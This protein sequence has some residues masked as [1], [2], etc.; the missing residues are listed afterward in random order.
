MIQLL[1][2]ALVPFQAP[3]DAAEIRVQDLKAH[4]G[5]LASDAMEGRESGERGGHLAARYVASQFER[6]GLQPIGKEPGGLPEDFLLPFEAAGRTC[7]NVAGLLPGTDPALAKRA[8]VIGGHHDHAGIG[9]P[10]AM[11]PPGQIHNGADDNASGTSGVLELA[12]WFAAHPARHPILFMTFSAEE[13]GL[14]GSKAFVKS[15]VFPARAMFAMINM[16]MVGRSTDGY[17][18]VGGLGTAEEFHPLLDGILAR[19]PLKIEAADGGSAPS[20]N[21]P[22]FQ[23]GVPALF[24]FTNVH[25]DYHLPTDDAGRINFKGEVQILG[26]VREV[27]ERLDR[28][29]QA[30]TFVRNGATALPADFGA[31]MQSEMRHARELRAQRGHLGIRVGPPTGKGILVASRDEG[32][33]AAKAG[34][35]AG[36]VI[37]SVGGHPTPTV[38]ELRKALGPLSKGTRVALQIFRDGKELALSATLE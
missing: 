28:A 11:G 30:L 33:A 32:S 3:A 2:L 17:L 24:F 1:L 21:T 19:S 35:L 27:L 15:G 34:I 4:I 18:F 38:G 20:D 31:R 29:S 13:R 12:E 10:G 16:D 9:G 22:F 37:E 7:F 14:L 5:F 6:F 23:A 8:F 25:D 36:D 26:L